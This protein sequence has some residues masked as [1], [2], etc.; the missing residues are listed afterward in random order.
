MNSR[1]QEVLPPKRGDC[2]INGEY[3]AYLSEQIITYIG[4]KRSLLDFI[5][6]GIHF[7]CRRLGKNKISSL[8]A[9]SGSGI[10]SRYLRRFSSSIHCNDL[11]DYSRVINE[12][13]MTNESSV[14]LLLLKSELSSLHQKIEDSWS[15]GIV[16]EMYAPA[17]EKHITQID[18]VFYTRR[19]A[20]YIDTARQAIDDIEPELR[21]FFLA[22]LLYEASVHNN[23]SGVFKGFYKNHKGI[24]QFGGHGRKALTRI[25]G[26]IELKLPVFS[27]F[28]VDCHI[29]QQDARQLM[30]TIPEVDFAYFDP[31][32]NQHP[33]GSNYFMLNIITN[34]KKP[35]AFSRIS[36]IPDNWN[37]S[38]YNKRQSAQDELFSTIRACPAKFILISYNSEGFI[39]YDDFIRFLSK[40]GRV[41]LLQTDYNTF[42]GC[43]NLKER[44]IKV[45]EFLFLV[46]KF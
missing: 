11:E 31:P 42:R 39:R 27:R 18:R 1:K 14:D 5:E 38:P 33:Y 3:P 37:R 15:E 12:C 28:D 34:N 9:F 23:T 43:R 22:P 16:T 20:I 8:D 7:V 26:D 17:D 4:N 45:T 29:H 2:D 35:E 41:H 44:S 30:N 36:G 32:Y 13:Y 10:V 40:I 25:L 6:K 21:K 19:N 24:G 46:E